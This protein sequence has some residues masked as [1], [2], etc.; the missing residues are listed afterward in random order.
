[1]SSK[2]K[3]KSKLQKQYTYLKVIYLSQP[4]YLFVSV[5]LICFVL[6]LTKIFL[7]KMCILHC[8]LLFT[9]IF[10]PCL[11]RNKD[12]LISLLLVLYTFQNN[13]LASVSMVILPTKTAIAF[14]E[15]TG[16]EITAVSVL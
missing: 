8:L 7:S 16:M 1:M 12:Y 14:V 6:Y 5:A 10:K 4:Y 2:G 11:F 15:A 13:A 3:N 9:I